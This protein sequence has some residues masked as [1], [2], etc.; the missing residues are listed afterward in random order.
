MTE[1][2]PTNGLIAGRYRLVE[3]LGRGSMG[4]VWRAHDERLDRVVA[5]KQLLPAAG[6][7]EAAVRDGNARAMREARITAK[8]QHPRA[9]A[10]HDVVEHDGQPCLVMEYVRARGLSSVLAERGPLPPMEAARIGE[11][12]AS[13]L[14]AAHSAGIVHRDV[15]PDNVLLTENGDAK[16]TDFGISRAV[17]DGSV[18][19]P[20]IV[21]GTPAYLAPE[22]A[23]GGEATYS[24][25]VFS[26]GATLY[27]AVEGRPPFGYD[28]NPIALL[29]R[30]A[31]G[32][33]PPPTHAGPLTPLLGRL[34]RAD[35][36]ARPAMLQ[37]VDELTALADG[38]VPVPPPPPPA[39]A[40]TLFMAPRPPRRRAV[41]AGLAAV[42]L[43]AAGVITGI[44]ISDNR[45]GQVAFDQPPP[46]HTALRP[47][48]RST[49]PTTGGAAN[50]DTACVA[51]YTVT[52]HWPGGFQAQVTIT[53]SGA[54]VHGWQV[55][56]S[57]PNGQRINQVWNGVLT[58]QGGSV[59]VANE[60]YNAAV[61]ADGTTGFGFL[62]GGTSG[63]PDVPPV[64]HCAA[65]R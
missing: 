47:T 55:T 51:A 6:L 41:L 16:I 52:N 36:T 63:Q 37:A 40:P 30:V 20:G 42:G 60:S 2:D 44:V 27:E 21:V 28:D 32:E 24:S 10:V 14:A 65:T 3:R 49:L 58:Q 35:P 19:G 26:L 61:A 48:P 31:K 57:L 7:D 39:P 43:V 59:T 29:Q 46:V 22:I 18:T 4:E 45:S 8:L 53:V 23:A 9:V 33:F 56:W 12:V 38:R 5:V 17:G 1:D 25:D 15:K 13:A 54:A 64:V 11:Q 62:G 50:P 34:L